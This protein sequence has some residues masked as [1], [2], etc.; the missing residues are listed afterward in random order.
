MADPLYPLFSVFAFLGFIL[1]LIPLPWHLQAWNSGTCYFMLWSALACLNL[2]VNSVV[3]H[4]N[5]LNP[6]PIWCEISIRILM[7]SS[8]GLP[9]ASL[10]IN[11]RLYHIANVQAVSISASEKRRQILID[12]MISVLFPMVYIALQYVVQGHRF[13]VLE[14]FGCK[15]ALYNTLPTYFISYMWPIL[16]GLISA[17]YCFLSLRCFIRRRVQFN[18]FLASNKSISAGRYFRLMALATTEILFTIPLASFVIYLNTVSSPIGPWISWEDTHFAFSRMEQIP[19]VLWRMNPKVVL[20]LELTRWASP[21]CAFVFFGFFGFADEAQRHYKMAFWAVLKPFGV[22]PASA[23]RAP[24]HFVS[25]GEYDGGVFAGV[26]TSSATL[27][28]FAND[29][30]YE[31]DFL[32]DAERASGYNAR[33]WCIIS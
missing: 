32:F 24:A 10:C 5:A 18:Q 23:K 9:A 13:D 19:G 1:S 3:W 4:G 27:P 2:F 7:G 28:S 14:D 16:I 30:D 33:G 26:P 22:K 20:A 25:I 21:F 6:S 17:V 8:V 29:P 12:T 31:L 15:P 11:R